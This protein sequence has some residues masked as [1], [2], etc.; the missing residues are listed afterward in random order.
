MKHIHIWI[1]VGTLCVELSRNE[2]QKALRDDGL[3]RAEYCRGCSTFRVHMSGGRVAL[4][5]GDATRQFLEGVDEE[6]NVTIHRAPPEFDIKRK[7]RQPP[8]ESRLGRGL[9]DLMESQPPMRV[10]PFDKEDR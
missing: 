10:T 1:P 2:V 5:Q 6:E 4:L 8:L 3:H 9:K 7:V